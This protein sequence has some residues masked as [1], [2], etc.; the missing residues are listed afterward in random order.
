MESQAPPHEA[1]RGKRALDNLEEELFK[2]E[3]GGQPDRN[4][5]DEAIRDINNILRHNSPPA[6][7]RAISDMSK[8][9]GIRLR[10]LENAANSGKIV[11]RGSSDVSFKWFLDAVRGQ[12]SGSP[13]RGGSVEIHIE[14]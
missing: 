3:T 7:A 14:Y 5:V 9:G 10:A 4:K 12:A 8:Y 1:Q 2:Q 11:L 13:I 6:V